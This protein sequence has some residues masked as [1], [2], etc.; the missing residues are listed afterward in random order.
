MPKRPE[1][2]K[3]ARR[4]TGPHGREERDGG[5][6]PAEDQEV[7]SW[8]WRRPFKGVEG[9]RP[10]ARRE[11]RGR[12]SNTYT[13][14]DRSGAVSRTFRPQCVSKIAGEESRIGSRSVGPRVRLRP[15]YSLT[16]ALS[17]REEGRA[18]WGPDVGRGRGSSPCTV[19]LPALDSG[20]TRSSRLQSRVPGSYVTWCTFGGRSWRTLVPVTNRDVGLP[21]G[22]QRP[23]SLPGRFVGPEY[24]G[25]RRTAPALGGPLRKEGR[26][27]R[28][29]RPV[30]KGLRWGKKKA[31]GGTTGPTR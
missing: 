4:G 20:V 22:S 30:R 11:P 17:S 27:P 9:Y 2:R 3:R 29:P 6:G 31:R 23:P 19:Y 7:Q 5:V 18:V 15:T 13:D 10:S 24:G 28:P 26:R 1:S 25:P 16:S 12:L 14:E 8:R 21:V